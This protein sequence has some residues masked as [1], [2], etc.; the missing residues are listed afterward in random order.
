MEIKVV[1]PKFMQESRGLIRA[2]LGGRVPP[3]RERLC[4][5][6]GW[7]IAA[8]AWVLSGGIFAAVGQGFFNPFSEA[9]ATVPFP[10]APPGAVSDLPTGDTLAGDNFLIQQGLPFNP[11]G[12]GGGRHYRLRLGRAT[13]S[14]SAGL[15][16]SYLDNVNLTSGGQNSGGGEDITMTASLGVGFNMKLNRDNNL[17][18]ILG[19]GYS[20]SFSRNNQDQ[21]SIG[22]SSQWDYRMK[23]GPVRLTFYDQISTPGS[24][25]PGPQVSG[26]GSAAAVNFHRLGNAIG[27]SA[28]V[29]RGRG[30][31]F[32]GGY[33]LS[34]DI[35]LGD[36]YSEQNHLTHSLNMAVFQRLNRQWTLG[37]SGSV[38]LNHY[39]AKFQNDSQGYGMGPILTWQ[40][41]H[42]INVSASARYSV[43]N[44]LQ[45]GKVADNNGFAGLTYDLAV[46]QSISK[47]MSH[48]L[49]GG[50]HVDLGLGS[51]FAKTLNASYNFSWAFSSKM[52]LSFV[53]SYTSSAQ[54]GFGYDFVAIPPGG[55]FVPGSPPILFTSTGAS[56]LPYGTLLT[57]G[58][59][60]AQPRT[61]ESYQF[62]SL[63]PAISTRVSDHIS[64]SLS[65]SRRI[66]MSNLAGHDYAQN[67]VSLALSYA[68]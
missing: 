22:P 31:T 68:F 8:P 61:S 41:T 35:G 33:T 26:T 15:S 24:L 23:L 67:A 63:S 28:A 56:A 55:L 10:V 48:G 52:S 5:A 9:G 16:T 14:L 20:H 6:H 43:A 47:R 30:T 64:A 7:W 17:Q 65:Y 18:F 37:V 19:I 29:Q 36:M 58:G 42:R 11:M 3:T 12:G 2:S 66:R 40:P 27:V 32:S 4:G 49:N 25:T 1:Q 50:S 60:L 54:T 53:S 57:P 45:T 51:N 44:S 34:T 62:L 59:L 46:Q 21:I 13:G 38:Y 39:F